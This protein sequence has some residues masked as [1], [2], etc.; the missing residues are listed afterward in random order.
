MS[1]RGQPDHSGILV[2]G[3][4]LAILVILFILM[5]RSDLGRFIFYV[6]LIL[7]QI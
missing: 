4:V 2:A 7:L 1:Q 6:L 3:I 5:W